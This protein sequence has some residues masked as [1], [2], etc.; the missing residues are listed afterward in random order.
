VSVAHRRLLRPPR[1]AVGPTTRPDLT[2]T[3]SPRGVA[4]TARRGRVNLEGITTF[5]T[6][7]TS[8][9]GLLDGVA[10]SEPQ[11]RDV[12]RPKYLDLDWAAKFAAI[13]IA[14]LGAGFLPRMFAT[15]VNMPMVYAYALVGVGISFAALAAIVISW[16]RNE[17][18][19]L[20]PSRRVF[21]LSA[22]TVLICS[23][24]VSLTYLA[25]SQARSQH[26]AGTGPLFDEMAA[27]TLRD[28]VEIKAS[29]AHDL[30]AGETFTQK[31]EGTE[32]TRSTEFPPGIWAPTGPGLWPTAQELTEQNC[33]RLV[34]GAGSVGPQRGVEW[35]HLQV[36]SRFCLQTSEGNLAG[37]EVTQRARGRV[38]QSS[39]SQICGA[40]PEAGLVASV[41]DAAGLRLT[42]TER[43]EPS[44]A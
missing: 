4:R 44:L 27:G 30:D 11:G 19:Q 15:L 35:A 26:A 33:S 31:T 36:G 38:I 16:L 1:R 20:S 6:R 41:V 24:A 25:T 9:R 43:R 3:R 40:R 17:R 29:T 32:L 13:S 18:P 34:D 37:F 2:P 7:T 8:V 12:E 10:V 42:R 14:L 22:W 23:I 28:E 39:S 21:A 5:S